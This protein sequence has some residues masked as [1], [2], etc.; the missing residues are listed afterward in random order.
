[1]FAG[2]IKTASN[3]ASNKNCG[4]KLITEVDGFQNIFAKNA[5]SKERRKQAKK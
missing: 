3:R 1:M 5:I 4:D 2:L